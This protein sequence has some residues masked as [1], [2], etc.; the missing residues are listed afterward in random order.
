MAATTIYQIFEESSKFTLD[1]F[2]KEKF[3]EF[4]QNKFP[5]G[6]RY[7]PSQHS[8]IL[9]IE[10]KKMEVIVLPT[11]PEQIFSV[12]VAFLKDK[13]NLRSTR[14]L[15]I[16]REEIDKILEQRIC[17]T[18]CEWSQIKPRNIKEQLIMEYVTFLRDKYSLTILETK[19]L[20]ALIQNGFKFHYISSEDVIYSN[21]KIK[22]IQG[23]Q[24]NKKTRKFRLP[25][26]SAKTPNRVIKQTSD[27]FYNTLD[28]YIKQQTTRKNKYL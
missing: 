27:V 4:S 28:K 13:L 16:E 5:Q 17:D 7:D 8:L 14:D 21:N 19:T 25:S 26:S 3:Q 23:L 10:G 11:K 20:M 18:N 6:V 22:K 15:K 2:W 24:Y 12:I 1:P 9:R